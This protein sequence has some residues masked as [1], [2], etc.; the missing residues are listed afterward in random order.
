[1]RRAEEAEHRLSV[2]E[3]EAASLRAAVDEVPIGVVVLGPDGTE[4]RRNAA[5]TIGGH[6]EVLIGAVIERLGSAARGGAVGDESVTLVGPPTRVLHVRAAPLVGGGAVVTVDDVS[7]RARLD[8][9]RTDFVTNISHELKTP[10]GALAVLAE[11]IS[12]TDDADVARRLAERMVEEAHRASRTIDDLLDLSRIELDGRGATEPVRLESVVRE[13]LERH[14]FNA[15][16]RRIALS[17]G[18]VCEAI[19]I[20]DRLQLVSAVSNL[21]DNAVKYS[22]EG[23]TVTVTVRKVDDAV[24]VSVAD[25]GVGI[26]AGDLG[27][28][29]ERFYRVDRARSRRTGGTGLGLAIVRHVAANHGGTVRVESQEGVGSRFELVL[30][31]GAPR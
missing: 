7:E 27:R 16:Q 23:G 15:E 18:E 6:G 4:V 25:T 1:M 12:D 13:V 11:T 20:G 10:V 30:P 26:P 5:A 28:V 3:H 14:R 22:N 9:V 21:V 31:I 19:V 29:F 8:A 24:V 2:V 17:T